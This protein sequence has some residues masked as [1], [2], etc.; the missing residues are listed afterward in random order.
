MLDKGSQEI[1]ETLEKLG[2]ESIRLQFTDIFG[3]IKNVAIPADQLPKALS[4]G[5]VFDGSAIEGFARVE[6]SDMYLIPD[7][8]TFKVFP[9]QSREGVMARIICDIRTP[10]G[11]PFPGCPRQVLKKALAGA[12]ALGYEMFVGSE[13][14]FFLFHTG[15]DGAPSLKTHDQGG[16]FDLTPLD[17]GEEARRKMVVSL[18]ELGFAVESS[19]HEASPGQHEIN[20]KYTDALTM[21]DQ[22]VTIRY[23]IKTMAQR[24][25]LHAT[26]MAKPRQDLKGSGMHYNQSLFS[27]GENLFFDEKAELGLSGTALSYMAGILQHA[28]A[29]TAITN[30]TVNSYK[31]LL[32]GFY[33]PVLISWSR[34]NRSALIRIPAE[35]GRTTRLELRSPDSTSNPYLALAVMLEAGLAGIREGLKPPAEIRH[36]LYREPWPLEAG[37]PRLPLTL[38]EALTELDRDPLVREVLG[39]HIYRSFSRAKQEEWQRY[40]HHVHPWELKEYLA[41]Y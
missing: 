13:T 37:I 10:G 23:L 3:L 20:V 25:G 26:F 6:E 7:P 19:H 5:M 1:L 27:G 15:R 33:A 12:R 2:V 16:Y 29:L 4:G 35:R 14:E 40:H 39:E 8:A 31:R 32:P 38:R 41:R 24:Y 9:W 22:M 21:A 30:P 36:N 18:Q 11:E 28:P 34:S 17:H